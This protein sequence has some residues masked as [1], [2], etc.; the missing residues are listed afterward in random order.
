MECNYHWSSRHTLV[1]SFCQNSS[2]GS[3]D[4]CLDVFFSY[5]ELLLKFWMMQNLEVQTDTWRLERWLGESW[6]CFRYKHLLDM[7][8]I[9]SVKGFVM[10][11]RG[12]WC[13]FCK[14]WIIDGNSV[15]KIDPGFVVVSKFGVVILDFTWMSCYVLCQQDWVVIHGRYSGAND[16]TSP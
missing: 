5:L 13:G 8:N 15:S 1:S 14:S 6:W 9:T 11:W 3:G 12:L 2:L 10:P 16:V 7:S 4:L